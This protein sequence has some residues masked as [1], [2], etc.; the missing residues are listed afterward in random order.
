VPTGDFNAW[1][2]QARGTGCALDYASYAELAKP[3]QDIP[4]TTYRSVEPKLFEHIMDQT[5]AAPGNA[6]IG[7]AWCPP[8]HQAG[9]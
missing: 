6:S 9:G 8:M 1:L 4:P 5:T 7:G 3:S 2:D